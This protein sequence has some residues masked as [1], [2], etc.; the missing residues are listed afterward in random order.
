MK[1]RINIILGFIISFGALIFFIQDIHFDALWSTLKRVKLSWVF[2]AVIILMLEFVLRAWRWKYLLAP[3]APQAS[4]ARLY[5]PQIIGVALN[6]LFPLRAGDFAKPLIAA[7]DLSLSFVAVV[8][9]TIMERVY[10]IMGMVF[11]L[12][13]ML[14]IATPIVHSDADLELVHNLQLYGGIFGVFSAIC[15]VIFFVL[16]AQKNQARKI[17]GRILSIA[18]APIQ[19][20]LFEFFDTFCSMFWIF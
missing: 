11:I 5:S 13:L 3:I 4:V 6:T 12:V 9:T 7:K 17:F 2:L 15:M 8:A 1:K 16:V 18:P 10:D 19:R 14:C 20:K